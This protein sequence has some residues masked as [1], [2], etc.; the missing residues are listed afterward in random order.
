MAAF[1]SLFMVSL[2]E[3]DDP[4]YAGVRRPTRRPV[5]L[6]KKLGGLDIRFADDIRILGPSAI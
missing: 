3:F 1:N 5:G 4:P 2:A 6:G